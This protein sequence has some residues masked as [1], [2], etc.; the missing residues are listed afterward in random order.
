MKREG[1]RSPGPW[2]QEVVLIF[3]RQVMRAVNVK[4]HIL[5]QP[6]AHVNGSDRIE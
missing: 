4:A 6:E 1:R 2:K 3:A 5:N